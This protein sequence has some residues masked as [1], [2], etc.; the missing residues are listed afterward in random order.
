[1]FQ[2]KLLQLI[3]EAPVMCFTRVTGTVISEDIATDVDECAEECSDLETCNW[4]TYNSE[5]QSCVLTADREVISD[6]STCIYGHDGCIREGS[7]GMPL[8]FSTCSSSASCLR[9]L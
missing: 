2:N 9:H 3:L 4:F 1:M 5:D 8:S 7:S 6:C